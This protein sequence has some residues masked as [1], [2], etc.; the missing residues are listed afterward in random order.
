MCAGRGKERKG[1]KP[2]CCGMR[3]V[4]AV[5]LLLLMLLAASM[6]STKKVR[7]GARWEPALVKKLATR[8]RALKT[9]RSAKLGG[10]GG[11]HPELITFSVYEALYAH[12]E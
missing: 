4:D 9:A 11:G 12:H 6:S 10:C 2:A 3:T 1:E 7:K 5:F 8:W